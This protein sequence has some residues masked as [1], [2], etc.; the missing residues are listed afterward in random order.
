MAELDARHDY[1]S[2]EVGRPWIV[3]LGVGATILVAAVCM[4][5]I[6]FVYLPY[7]REKPIELT[8]FPAPRLQSAPRND[9]AAL[10]KAQIEKL[11]RT[12]WRKDEPGRAVIPIE[13]AMKAVAA[14]GAQAFAPLP[15]LED[16][17][18]TADRPADAHP[19]ADRPSNPG[20]GAAIPMEAPQ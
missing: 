1:E 11:H 6:Y 13:A 12:Q 18:A 8:E 17:A 3:A 19:P 10:E 7:A 20:G 15:G 2:G 16:A 5:A 14:R 4:V 9:L